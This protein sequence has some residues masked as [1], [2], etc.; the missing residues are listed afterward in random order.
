[1]GTDLPL[2]NFVLDQLSEENYYKLQSMI[3]DVITPENVPETLLVMWDLRKQSIS[4]CYA[5]RQLPS[6]FDQSVETWLAGTSYTQADKDKLKAELEEHSDLRSRDVACKC[7]IKAET[8]PEFKYPRPIKSRTDRFKALVGPIFQGINDIL[9]EDLTSFIKKIPVSDRP[10]VLSELFGSEPQIDCTDF[11]SFEAHFIKLVMFCIEL[12]FYVWTTNNLHNQSTFLNNVS[13]IMNKNKCIFKYFTCWSESRAS[14]EMNTSSGNG[15]SNKTL[16][17]YITRVK[18]AQSTKQQFEG[19]DGIVAAHPTASLP[20]TRDYEDLG[21][22]CKLISNKTFSEA[23]FCGIVSDPVDLI[24][25]C[26]VRAYMADFGW[27]RQQYLYANDTTLRA[28]IRAKGYSAIYQYPGCPIIDALGHYALRITNEERIQKKMHKMFLSGYLADSRYK[29]QRFILILEKFKDGIPS[30]A[31]SPP[32]TRLLVERLFSISVAKQLE[33]ESYLDNLNTRK[34]LDIDLDVP[35]IWRYTYDQYVDNFPQ[36]S[37]E[38]QLTRLITIL[39]Q[40][41]NVKI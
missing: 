29:N 34:V 24:N 9:F 2:D 37:S 33:I 21:W 11:T 39:K 19:D 16:F 18:S 31:P 35:E 36:T 14:G 28:L 26:D 13:H 17:S 15:Y 32:N 12:P 25:V 40:Y 23:S 4:Q 10:R 38:E 1:M 22:S 3:S 41:P 20:L 8:Y 27:T 5:Y 6:N 30:R 7:F